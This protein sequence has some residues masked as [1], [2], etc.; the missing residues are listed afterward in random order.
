MCLPYC[1]DPRRRG[2]E[3][4]VECPGLL[5]QRPG[6]GL[7]LA[8]GL[9]SLQG[10][11]L[12]AIEPLDLL[13]SLA[14]LVLEL[15]ESGLFRRQRGLGALD[16]GRDRPRGLHLL[17][18]LQAGASSAGSVTAAG[19]GIEQ[20]LRLGLLPLQLLA[21]LMP[22]QL[23]GDRALVA[24]QRS[25]LP[26]R[27]SQRGFGLG[28]VFGR[29]RLAVLHLLLQLVERHALGLHAFEGPH[30]QAREGLGAGQGLQQ[31]GALVVA[32][33]EEGAEVVLRQQH[34]AGE[35]LEG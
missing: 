28:A 11:L 24:L 23:F 8:G 10:L 6:I 15:S 9:L 14:D 5:Q 21:L 27:I 35:L 1:L 29:Q 16:L 19:R 22:A 30:R 34:R 3:Q 18:P 31:L 7:R 17:E 13:A 25:Q 20:R 32:R 26:Y 4:A 33:L 2:R 12:L